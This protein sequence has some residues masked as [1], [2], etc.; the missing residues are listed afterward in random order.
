MTDKQSVLAALEHK[1]TY[2][3]PYQIDFTD[4]GWA[5]PDEVGL[6][7][8]DTMNKVLNSRSPNTIKKAMYHH[9]HQRD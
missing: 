7:N 5:I 1:Q 9:L 2:P 3:V 8:V 4:P 6:E